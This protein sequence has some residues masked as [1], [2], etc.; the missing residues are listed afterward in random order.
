MPE[1]VIDSTLCKGD[2]LC[3]TV[4]KFGV[5]RQVKSGEVPVVKDESRTRCIGCGQC[6]AICPRG[7]ISHETYPD[8]SINAVSKDLIPGYEQV[9]ELIRT[10]R[11]KRLFKDQPVEQELIDKILDAARFAPSGHNAQ[12]T[13]FVVVQGSEHVKKVAGLA[14]DGMRSLASPFKSPVGRMIMRMIMG[15]RG[16]D[17]VG[18]LAPELDHLAKAFDNGQDVILH[19]APLL[20]LFSADRVSDFMAAINAN[21]ALQNATLAAESLGIGSF[22]TGFIV[23]AS[24]RSNAIAEYVGLPETHTIYGGLALGY[25]RLS[26]NRWPERKTAKTTWLGFDDHQGV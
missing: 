14:A 6:V 8:G 18:N 23:M 20:V 15:R 5:F 7:A 2:G 26:F 10:R 11:S 1:I 19:E 9:L 12:G 22:Y 13:E 17:Y 16:A 24:R 21:L 3:S 25:P 4:C